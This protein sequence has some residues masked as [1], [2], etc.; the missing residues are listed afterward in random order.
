[1]YISN[2]FVQSPGIV[3]PLLQKASLLLSDGDRD[4]LAF[5]LSR[6][7]VVG[8]V[9]LGRII[10]ATTCGSFAP[11]ESAQDG[12]APDRAEVGEGSLQGFESIFVS[13]SHVLHYTPRSPVALLV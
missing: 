1:M 5:H 12:A 8:P 4:R 2:D 6:P 9:Q 13:L 11:A 10:M 3:N 7:F